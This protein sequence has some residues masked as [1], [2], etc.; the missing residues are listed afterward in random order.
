MGN[1]ILHAFNWKFEEIQRKAPEIKEIGYSA[2]LISPPALSE[3][4]FWYDRYQPVDYRMILSPLGDLKNLTEM[5]GALKENGLKVFV[6]IVFNHMAHRPD[7][8]LD[9]PGNDML[10]RYQNEPAFKENQLFGNLEENLF[11]SADFNKKRCITP[12]AYDDA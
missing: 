10:E 3:G 1:V 12:D 4:A 6:D 9:F 5:I 7:D 2:V 8:H 11:S